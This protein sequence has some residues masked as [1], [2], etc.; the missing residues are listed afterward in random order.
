METG[1][2][3]DSGLIRE[4]GDE[5]ELQ[6]AAMERVHAKTSFD[7]MTLLLGHPGCGKSTLLLALAG[8]L[9]P[10]LKVHIN[11]TYSCI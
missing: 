10:S 6:M 7:R 2:I 8:K 1:A 4:E 9:D 11:A 3:H 5:Y